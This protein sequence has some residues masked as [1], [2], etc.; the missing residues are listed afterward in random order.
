MKDEGQHRLCR[1][2]WAYSRIAANTSCTSNI[3]A[4][5]RRFRCHRLGP[6]KD[7]CYTKCLVDPISLALRN[8]QAFTAMR[9]A[10][11]VQWPVYHGCIEAVP[12]LFEHSKLHQF[13]HFH[14]HENR[15]SPFLTRDPHPPLRLCLYYAHDRLTMPEYIVDLALQT[16]KVGTS[17]VRL[18]RSSAAVE[19]AFLA[20]IVNFLTSVPL[21]THRMCPS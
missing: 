18:S 19:L 16:T 7:S 15:K 10:M 5:S 21:H 17:K 11:A 8:S 14:S 1:K 3:I 9:F 20:T 6:L 12:K 13:I 2:Q 4:L